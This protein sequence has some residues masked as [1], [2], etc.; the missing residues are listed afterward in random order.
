MD[1]V[2]HILI[3]TAVA[4]IPQPSP[5]N[6]TPILSWKQRV[7]VGGFA[8]IFPDIDY[9]LFW[10]NPLEFLAYWHRAETHSL[11]LAPLWAGLIAKGFAKFYALDEQ[12]RHLYLISLLAIISHILSDSLTTFGTQWFAPVS[13]Y[14]VSFDLLFVIDSYFTLSIILTLVVL[15]FARD[16]KYRLFA[17]LLPLFYLSAVFLIKD[18]VTQQVVSNSQMDI[19]NNTINLLPL[20]F[21][22]LYWQ[23]IKREEKSIKQAYLTLRNDRIAETVTQIIRLKS[24]QESLYSPDEPEWLHHSVLPD[25]LTLQQQA[26]TAWKH[27]QFVAFRH[28]SKYPVF[29]NYQKI[30]SRD[31]FWF[32]DLRYHWPQITP[33]FRFAM[34]QDK[35]KNWEVRRLKYFSDKNQKIYQ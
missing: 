18:N 15:Y 11:L 35:N 3:G 28:F 31:C 8:A 32:S 16:K 21:S 30:P 9:V 12:F 7:L 34:C 4:Q 33:S 20:P 27:P 22:P 6:K 24:Y 1:A 14:K 25:N 2:T 5:I 19:N 10:L 13:D 23:A 29:L 17:F 26:E